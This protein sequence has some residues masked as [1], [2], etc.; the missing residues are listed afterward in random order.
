MHFLLS[1]F[2]V[3]LA[4]LTEEHFSKQQYPLFL[5]FYTVEM[6]T[7]GRSHWSSW[8]GNNRTTFFK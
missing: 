6:V 8:S 3:T 4:A 2:V 5:V 1:V 7:T